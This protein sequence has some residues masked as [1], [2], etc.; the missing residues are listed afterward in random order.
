MSDTS[1]KT[2]LQDFLTYLQEQRQYSAYTCENYKRDLDRLL[3]FLS[4]Q[5]VSDWG[6]VELKHI[7]HWVI[8]LHQKGLGGRSLQRMLSS[9][10]S[11]Y[12]Y[13]LKQGLVKHNPALGVQA[14]K[15]PRKL[16]TAPDVDQ[17]QQMLNASASNEL[18]VRD[19]AI[20]ELVYSSGLRLAELLSLNLNDIDF[21]EG[22]VRVTGKGNR[23][24]VIPLGAQAIAAIQSWL[25]CRAQFV[26]DTEQAVF[27]SKQGKRLSPRGVQKRFELWGNQYASQH[28]HPHM[29]RHSFAS[30][31]L[32][33]SGNLRAVQELL[34][35]SNISTTQIYTHL[36]FQ[37]LAKSYDAAHPRAKKVKPN[38]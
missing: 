26:D 11:L 2:H 37:H 14:P 7:R 19:L 12:R 17:T 5:A 3:Q 20:L 9:T 1:L 28:L 34:G 36:D 24:R 4:D 30:H 29:L 27:I 38:D 8:S 32:E 15:S 13:L 21:S 23:T 6:T 16:P 25:Q 31:L 22:L 18:E 35:H 33:S 10:R